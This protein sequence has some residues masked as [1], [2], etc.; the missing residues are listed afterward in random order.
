MIPRCPSSWTVAEVS[1]IPAQVPQSQSG[2]ES[3]PLAPQDSST[4]TASLSYLTKSYRAAYS[5]KVADLGGPWREGSGQQRRRARSFGCYLSFLQGCGN[6]TQ[7]SKGSSMVFRR[8][9]SKVKNNVLVLT[10]AACDPVVRGT[11]LRGLT[12]FLARLSKIQRGAYSQVVVVA[13]RDV[14][15]RQC[16]RGSFG[17]WRVSVAERAATQDCHVYYQVPR[18]GMLPW[19]FL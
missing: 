18:K 10:A 11:N 8:Q 13:S 19:K 5:R 14:G 4:A 17:T 9:Q 3:V 7:V 1:S 15:V 12:R 2:S 16:S 6:D